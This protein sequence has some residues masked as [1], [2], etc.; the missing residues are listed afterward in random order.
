M[1]SHIVCAF[2]VSLLGSVLWLWDLLYCYVLEWIVQFRCCIEF[3][4]ILY[5][6]SYIHSP[7]GVCLDCSL[8]LAVR[9]DV[10]VHIIF[11]SSGEHMYAF[12][13]CLFIEVELLTQRICECST[14]IATLLTVFRSGWAIWPFYTSASSVWEF[15][16]L[17]ISSTI[18]IVSSLNFSYCKGCIVVLI[19]G[20]IY[21]SLTTIEVEP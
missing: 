11:M 2:W 6:F 17:Y 13:L 18:G 1:R 3:H 9:N 15:Q 14:F 8:F 19:V 7:I 21:I 4:C 10:A 5:I 16:L 20:L 12:V